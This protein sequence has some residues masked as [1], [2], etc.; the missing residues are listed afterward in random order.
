MAQ[1]FHSTDKSKTGKIVTQNQHFSLIELLIVIAIMTILTSLI[2]PALK[3]TMEGASFVACASNME[4]IAAVDSIYS[5]DHGDLV[6]TVAPGDG[7]SFLS[8][9]TGLLQYAES[10]IMACPNDPAAD[11]TKISGIGN[12]YDTRYASYG[13]N[14][15]HRY[16]TSIYRYEIFRPNEK[17]LY[18]DKVSRAEGNAWAFPM[19]SV[20]KTNEHGLFNRHKG[21]LANVLFVDGHA[22]PLDV[23]LPHSL[24]HS[25]IVI[26]Y[27]YRAQ[28]AHKFMHYN[29]P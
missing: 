15:Y 11:P 27:K 1:D 22:S 2:S 19:I 8:K 7:R 28:K 21:M 17:L 26:D 23:L 24:E 4:K 12:Q 20:S 13:G 10:T 29:R 5:E 16:D 18:G 6:H 14:Y 3:R 25:N 9:N